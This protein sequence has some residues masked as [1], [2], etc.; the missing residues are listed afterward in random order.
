MTPPDELDAAHRRGIAAAECH[1]HGGD[2]AR[3]REL[4]TAVLAGPLA[5][6]LQADA[7]R[8]L[9]EISF[10]EERALE[11]RQLYE[12]ALG[13]SDDPSLLTRIE[14]GLAFLSGQLDDH[15]AG[16][17]HARRARAQAEA[18][19]G[20]KS[21][22]APALALDTLC[23]F[24]GGHGLDWDKMRRARAQDDRA[25]ILPLMW[26]PDTVEALL[27]LYLGRHAE[28]RERL[29][30]V[31]AGARDRGDE[32]DL[33]FIGLWRSWLETR[34]GDYAA[35]L[36]LAEEALALA[37]LT[38]SESVR[39]HLLAQRGLVHACRGEAAAA[40]GDCAEAAPRPDHPWVGVWVAAARTVL[41]L[42]RGDG[43][44]A[45]AACREI[46]AVVEQRG[47][48]EPVLAFFVPDAIEALIATGALDRAETLLGVFET[49][50]RELHRDWAQAAAGRCRGLLLA[51]R[52]DLLGARVALDQALAWHDGLDL[53]LD[54][55]RTLLASGSV[56]R[57]VRK[58]ARAR[59]QLEQAAKIC[60]QL[61]AALWAQRARQELGQLTTRR[62]RNNELTEAERR[63]A[64][65]L[66]AGLTNRA[67]AAA[68]FLSPK[69]VEAHLSSIY[70]KLGVDSRAGLGAYMAG[71]PR[72][73]GNN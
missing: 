6:P 65:A 18:A 37:S 40:L 62:S 17:R 67:A 24:L 4:L 53:P 43:G 64:E 19:T 5:R 21:L 25:A 32:S 28:A 48:T 3:A 16:S 63:V 44:A 71:H 15:A 56:Q 34:S 55:A 26:Q 42:S 45:W 2:R 35:A 9:A 46:T 7:L 68:L 47:I 41:E 11:A 52:G 10:N 8:L 1:V 70:R 39:R 54:L 69:T 13:Y 14:L 73:K 51:A 20:D 61:G 60:E 36:T 50:G 38:G 12:E 22:L 30:E 33:A 72:D 57:R 29:A 27:L 59:D 66:A 49:R 23:E 31:W 58:T